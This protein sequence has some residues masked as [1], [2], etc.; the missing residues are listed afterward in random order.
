MAIFSDLYGRL[1]DRELGS[2]DRTQLFTTVERKAAINEG[3]TEFNERTE[4]FAKQ[5]S[6][7]LTT[8]TQEYDLDTTVTDFSRLG[9][10][11][12]SIV[13]GS[14][15]TARYVGGDDLQHTTV[16]ELNTA[17]P[18]WRRWAAA[19]PQ[20]YYL[21]RDGGSLY[22]GLHPKPSFT[23]VATALLSYLAIP[24]A[25]TL[26]ADVPFTVGP[27]NPLSSLAPYHQG[28]VHWAAYLLEKFRKDEGR[29]Q[30]QLALFDSV[31]AKYRAS[32]VPKD[33]QVVRL[34]TRYRRP[35]GR[36][37]DPRVFP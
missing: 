11:G 28:L 14:G 17:E 35:M 37:L 34:A 10:Q 33:G 23:G 9:S 15:S 21:R 22:L 26:D 12:L 13:F 18:S 24:P 4:C 20:Q 25:M 1:L 8:G 29:Q 16:N 27:N 6:V 32:L 30:V 7:S 5:V 36:V 19:T 3:Q 31:V 2:A